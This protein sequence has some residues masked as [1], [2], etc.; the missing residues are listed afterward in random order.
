MAVTYYGEVE[1]YKP[2]SGAYVSSVMIDWL[3]MSPYAPFVGI[4]VDPNSP[5][6]GQDIKQVTPEFAAS[7]LSQDV[8]ENLYL[9]QKGGY[10]VASN[11]PFIFPEEGQPA[12]APL[13]AET[14]PSE[15]RVYAIGVDEAGVVQE[16]IETGPDIAAQRIQSLP[17]DASAGIGAGVSS[18]DEGL[19]IV[20]LLAA[21]A[22]G[23]G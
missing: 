21:A 19:G 13:R 6:F 5:T 7:Y 2:Q 9:L 3:A 14:V 17:N 10:Y 12:A 16:I 20:L 15:T 1:Q 23:L 22:M 11:L 8:G 18:G 4:D